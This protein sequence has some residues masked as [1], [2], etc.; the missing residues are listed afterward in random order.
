MCQKHFCLNE[1]FLASNVSVFLFLSQPRVKRIYQVLTDRPRKSHLSH[2]FEANLCCFVSGRNR[3]K[4]FPNYSWFV[5]SWPS[6]V[7]K[8]TGFSLK[9][10]LRTSC[11]PYETKHT[12]NGLKTF[13]NNQ[14]I[15][16]ADLHENEANRKTSIKTIHVKQIQWHMFE[17]DE[18]WM[19]QKSIQ[20]NH[21]LLEW[22][23]INWGL[24]LQ[25]CQNLILTLTSGR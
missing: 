21:S 24:V 25:H 16:L 19:D 18:S 8:I 5:S 14:S 15:V 7:Q 1:H 12:F 11:C 23:S 4:G 22:T 2:L 6:R 17:F 20:D 10:I 9:W 3:T 13:L